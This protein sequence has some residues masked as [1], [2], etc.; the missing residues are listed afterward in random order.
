MDRNEAIK[1]IK[2]NWPEIKPQLSEAI[3]ILIPELKESEDEKTFNTV[4]EKGD[5]KL[6]E[7]DWLKSLK[8]RVQP[9][10]SIGR[11]FINKHLKC[12]IQYNSQRANL[13]KQ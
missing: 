3:Q 13:K 11:I 5:L 8:E 6:S 12:P 4:I 7:I 2:D 1:V 9:K 10:Q